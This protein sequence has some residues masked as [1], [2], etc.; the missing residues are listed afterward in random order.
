MC[1]YRLISTLQRR[2]DLPEA[3]PQL[4]ATRLVAQLAV[5]LDEYS[6]FQVASSCR[7]NLSSISLNSLRPSCMETI[8][9]FGERLHVLQPAH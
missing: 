5:I 4:A 6:A 2:S 9:A 1:L 8:V 3:A 7:Y